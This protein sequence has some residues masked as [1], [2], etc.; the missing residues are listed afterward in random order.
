MRT[1]KRIKTKADKVQQYYTHNFY[2]NYHNA[3]LSGTCTTCR[4]TSATIALITCITLLLLL[5]QENI[6][7]TGMKKDLLNKE[8]THLRS[9]AHY[10]VNIN[11]LKSIY[12]QNRKWLMQAKGAIHHLPSW[13]TDTT[14]HG[15]TKE[16]AKGTGLPPS[17]HV[18]GGGSTA[19]NTQPLRIL[20]E[21]DLPGGDLSTGPRADA[22]TMSQCCQTCSHTRDCIG[23]TFVKA[24]KSCWLKN[25]A[26]Q[27]TSN[28]GTV[29]GILPGKEAAIHRDTEEFE[30]LI[31]A[32]FEKHE[33][34]DQKEPPPLSVW[35]LPKSINYQGGYRKI[36]PSFQFTL[37]G[38]AAASSYGRLQRTLHRYTKTMTTATPDR[39]FDW[40]D[41]TSIMPMTN[42]QVHC[43]QCGLPNEQNKNHWS[44]TDKASAYTLNVDAATDAHAVSSGTLRS[45]TFAGLIAGLE[46]LT[47]ICYGGLCNTTAF[48]IQDVAHYKWRGVMLDT[49]RRFLPVPLLRIIIDLMCSLHFN[50]LHLH[51][52]DWSAVRWKSTAFDGLEKGATSDIHRQYTANDIQ[53]LIEFAQDRGIYV[54]PEM[55]VPGH[56]SSFRPLETLEKE[57]QPSDG[58][59]FCG[60]RR[61]QLYNDPEHHTLHAL[62]KLATEM[63]GLFDSSIVH[64]GGDETEEQGKCKKQDIQALTEAMQMHVKEKLKKTPMVWNEVHT[65]L[66]KVVPGT[67]VQ[68]WNNCNVGEIAN[69]GHPVIYS[70]MR[71]FY[72]DFVSKSCTLQ[73]ALRGHCLWVDISQEITAASAPPALLLGGTATMWTDE[74]CPRSKCVGHGEGWGGSVG[75]MYE[76]EKDDEF[77]QSLLAVMFPRILLV[78]GSLYRFDPN[79]SLSSLI[80]HYVFAADRLERRAQVVYAQEYTTRTEEDQK[81]GG[82]GGNG[83]KDG[84][85][86]ITCPWHCRG[87]C[88]MLS[89]CG[90]NYVPR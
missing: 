15:S 68:C 18:C 49:G 54:V 63:N 13:T 73:G 25:N 69:S 70:L 61:Q 8:K 1:R 76:H 16:N 67:I 78:A 42:I 53:H 80:E 86:S 28:A 64:V 21:V 79:L 56:A 11:R 65:V 82:K 36:A 87:G 75:W 34:R 57:G 6:S 60:N 62:Q 10:E 19:T 77:S 32:H 20:E 41:S 40:I 37:M 55:D 66:G 74:Y 38:S 31:H 14:H 7:L 50:I 59:Q 2:P 89:R 71:D 22:V 23:F 30:Q 48:A 17:T 5:W 72:L 88:T 84:A 27:R 24:T 81:K 26:K 43:T 51:L 45:D 44:A 4:T 85:Q 29:S 12:Q 35:P 39:T 33:K 9:M 90:V 83:G 3:F 58:V 46:T 52:T 47:Q